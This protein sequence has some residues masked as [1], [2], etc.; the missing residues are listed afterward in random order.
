LGKIRIIEGIISANG[1]APFIY[2]DVLFLVSSLRMKRTY[3]R[4]FLDLVE[5]KG[6][7]ALVQPDIRTFHHFVEHHYARLQGPRLIDEISRLI[8]LEGLASNGSSTATSL[9]RTGPARSFSL[10]RARR[11]DRA[12]FAAWRNAGDLST[13]FQDAGF[14]D[15]PQIGLL[16][17]VH[18]GYTAALR[19][20]GLID[21]AGMLSY[22]Y[23]HFDPAWFSPY[24][25]II[26]DVSPDVG[27]LETAILRKVAECCACTF[28]VDAPSPD[29]LNR[30]HGSH[31]L[32]ITRDFLSNI[33]AAPEQGHATPSPDDL[34]LTEAL[35][36]ETSFEDAARNAPAPDSFSKDIRL[37]STV[38]TREEVSL[39]AGMVKTSLRNGIAPDSILVAFPSLDEYGPLVEEIFIDYGIP[40]NRALGRQV[41]TSAVAAAVISLLG[42]CQENF[43]GLSLLRIFSSPFL[44]FADEP[45]L[46]PALDRFV[47]TRR[48]TGGKEK[49]LAALKYHAPDEQGEDILSGPL[50]ELFI[51]LKPFSTRDPA[52]SPSGWIASRT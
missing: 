47:R 41:S 37:L 26:I 4:L 3:G 35:F 38:N 15:K 12:A 5:R 30:A 17:D 48:I 50:N 11:D 16:I 46:A 7:L 23:E 14:L 18:A 20:R 9:T 22:L 19:D 25:E 40:Y 45:S 42:A 10:G 29:M 27:R 52:P 28:L 8:L 1:N 39:I 13:R 21:P 34:F 36:S 31:P 24:R 44:K 2:N 51:A 33:N 32:S 49:L 6:S 43:S